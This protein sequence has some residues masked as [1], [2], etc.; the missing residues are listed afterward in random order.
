M[1]V[2][3]RRSARR[4]RCRWKASATPRCW[5]STS[6]EPLLLREPGNE[7]G[8][9]PLVLRV[10]RAPRQGALLRHGD[11]R[12][13]EEHHHRHEAGRRPPRRPGGHAEEQQAGPEADLSEVVRVPRPAPQAHL[14]DGAVLPLVLAEGAQLLVGHRLDHDR[15]ERH[16]RGHYVERAIQLRF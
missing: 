2:T 3:A 9:A 6:P 13:H 7:H 5:C 8:D 14:A 4:R 12:A 16:H 10:V 1:K 15:P 11:G